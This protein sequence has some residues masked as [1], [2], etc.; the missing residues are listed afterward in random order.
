[1]TPIYRY[2]RGETIVIYLEAVNPA[3]GALDM[4]ED[5]TAVL[6]QAINGR[7]VPPESA[8]VKAT[9]AVA[10]NGGG[11]TVGAGWTLTLDAVATAAL[12]PGAYVTNAV[13]RFVGGAVEKTEPL[14]IRIDQVTS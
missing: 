14:V 3:P 4:V 7:L 2:Q 8:P 11:D 1:V 10:P 6:K 9:F 12:D 5:V 13:L